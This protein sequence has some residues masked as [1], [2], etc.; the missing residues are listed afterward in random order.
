LQCIHGLCFKCPL[1]CFSGKQFPLLEMS[2]ILRLNTFYG[3]PFMCY[4]DIAFTAVLWFRLVAALPLAGLS[5]IFEAW[6][7]RLAEA[8][9]IP[10]PR[11]PGGHNVRCRGCLGAGLARHVIRCGVCCILL[12]SEEEEP[13]ALAGGRIRHC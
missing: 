8:S 4:C 6:L 9:S 2:S 1:L 12:C 7:P 10:W 13:T 11:S 5:I 3:P